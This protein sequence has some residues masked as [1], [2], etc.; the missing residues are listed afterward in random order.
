LVQ[1][2]KLASI[3]L[4]SAGIAHEIN[5]PL[6]FVASN[7]VVLQRS[8]TGLMAILAAFDEARNSLNPES[9]AKVAELAE[10]HDLDYIRDNMERLLGRTREGVQR[11]TK[12]VQGLRSL[13]RTSPSAGEEMSVGDLVDGALEL[14][15]GRML[16]RGIDLVLDLQP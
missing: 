1:S 15:R 5:N 14:V 3:G 9:A 8:F 16:R 7:L 13:A 6:A 10:E 12:I 11:V 2:E 4:L